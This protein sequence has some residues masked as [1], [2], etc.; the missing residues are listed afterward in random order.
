[1]ALEEHNANHS[2]QERSRAELSFDELAK[3]VA[4]GTLSRRKA[5][6]LLGAALVGG[7]LASMPGV[8][9]AAGRKGGNRECVRCC[10]EKYGPGRKRGQCISAGARGECPVTCDGNGGG[11]SPCE[12]VPV[13]EC[14]SN[15]RGAQVCLNVEGEAVVEKACCPKETSSGVTCVYIICTGDL[16]CVCCPP[17]GPC[18]CLM[19]NDPC[20]SAPTAISCA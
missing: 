18:P 2:H 7:A 20:V 9:W 19:L 14:P 17:G 15:S 4:S 8:A 6:R 16:V 10:K 1:M 13:L 12:D 11:E 3:D 5:L